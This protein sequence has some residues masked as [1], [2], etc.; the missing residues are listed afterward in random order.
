MKAI[1]RA[2]ATAN[3]PMYVTQRQ[4]FDFCSSHFSMEPRE[5]ELYR[6]I[7]LDGHIHGRYVGLDAHQEALE[8]DPDRLNARFLKFATRIASDAA[9]QALEQAQC[10][11]EDIGGLVVNTCTGYLCPGISSYVSQELGLPPPVKVLDLMGMGCGAAIPNMECA[12]GMLA[13]GAT[14]SIL[15][16]AVEI[17]SATMVMG[18]EPDLVVSN[19]IFGDGA[20]A[21]VLDLSPNG[22]APKLLR[23]LDFEAGILPAYREQLRYRTE[24]GRLR[25]VLSKRVPVLGA[26]AIMQVV[27]RL[28]ARNRLSTQEIDWWVVHAGGAAVLQQV[29]KKLELGDD[30]LRF[31]YDVFRDYGNMSSPTVMFVLKRIIEEGKPNRGDKGL[32][33]SFGAGFSAFGALVEF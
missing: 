4:V 22:D 11:P 19:C 32:L 31:S 17:C 2:L 14:K 28:L 15:S 20:S 26:A 18:P 7:L 25:N 16:I 13:M 12:A 1:L 21:A 9:R 8:T 30:A 10:K 33:L 24:Q 29:G 27:L 6:R 23:L 5:R 3:P